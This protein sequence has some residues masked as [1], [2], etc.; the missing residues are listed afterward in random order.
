MCFDALQA[1]LQRLVQHAGRSEPQAAE[2]SWVAVR[3][4]CLLLTALQHF[5]YASDLLQVISCL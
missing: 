2:L 5:N 1:F 3:C 4:M